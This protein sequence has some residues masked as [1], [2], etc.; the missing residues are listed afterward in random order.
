MMFEK[1]FERCL[2]NFSKDVFFLFFFFLFF[3]DAAEIVFV[4]VAEIRRLVLVTWQKSVPICPKQPYFTK[5]SIV[6]VPKLEE[7]MVA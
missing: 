6:N 5:G 1:F 2:R 3:A 7:K 4:D